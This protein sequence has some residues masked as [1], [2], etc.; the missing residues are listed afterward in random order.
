LFLSFSN[1]SLGGGM[2]T[3][4]GRNFARFIL[5]MYIWF[6]LIVRTGY[7]GVQFDMMLKEMRPKDVETIDE[8]IANNYTIYFNKDWLQTVQEMDFIKR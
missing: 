7:Q 2:I 4:P 5:M 6:A 3:L 1:I 8:V